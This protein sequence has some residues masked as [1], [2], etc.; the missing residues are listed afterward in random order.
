MRLCLG[1]LADSTSLLERFEK[2][3]EP[4]F[5][6]KTILLRSNTTL[7]RT[8]DL[9]LPKLISGE[10]DVSRWVEG[11]MKEMEMQEI[12]VGSTPGR[13]PER[14]EPIDKESLV[15]HSLWE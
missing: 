6:Q 12:V 1:H 5:S 7:R 9:L 10:L 4:I 14:A 2:V 3:I 13:W 8:R 11:E 15:W